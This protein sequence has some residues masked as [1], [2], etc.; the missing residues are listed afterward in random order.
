MTFPT[1]ILHVQGQVAADG[2][3]P[4]AGARV[5]GIMSDSVF[6]LA[7][8]WIRAALRL[9]PAG[10]LFHVEKSC[11]QWLAVFVPELEGVV[12]IIVSVLDGRGCGSPGLGSVLRCSLLRL[13]DL[14]RLRMVIQYALQLVVVVVVVCRKGTGILAPRFLSGFSIRHCNIAAVS[15]LCP[16]RVEL[17]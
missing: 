6:C 8:S 7:F 14:G 9:W 13:E 11:C 10:C 15:S 2:S 12:V 17:L 16:I 5:W 3:A 1:A 4:V